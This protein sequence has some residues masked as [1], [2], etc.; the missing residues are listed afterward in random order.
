MLIVSLPPA[1]QKELVAKIAA[2]PAVDAV[3]FNT[4]MTS[5]FSPEETISRYLE[6]IEPFRKPLYVDLKGKQLRVAEWATPPYGAIVLNHSVHVEFP[7]RVYFRGDDQ[8]E[9]REVVDGNKIF[10][11]P[12]PRAPVGKGQSVN[13]VGKKV[14]VKGGLLP[15]DHEY[16]KAALDH[17]VTRFLLSFVE[18]KDDVTELENAIA[19]HSRGRVNPEQCEIIFKIESQAGVDFVR[20]LTRVNFGEDSPYRIMAARDDLLIQIGLL[21]VPEALALMIDRDPGAICASQLLLG[22]EHGAVSL[23]DLS[24]L[25]HMRALGYQHFMFSDEISREHSEQALEF[26]VGYTASAVKRIYAAA[27]V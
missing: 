8:C 21:N 20:G 22:L 26:W 6:L 13:I 5:A 3:R 19:R 10:V 12:I 15:I 17:G 25:E 2:H 27:G 11:D 24:D 14:T 4:G 1:H 16:I 23:A 18:N 9:L 7:A